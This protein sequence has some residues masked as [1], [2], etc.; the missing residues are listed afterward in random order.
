[1]NIVAYNFN[2][3]IENTDAGIALN[4]RLSRTA[5]VSQKNTV[6]KN[7]NEMNKSHFKNN[8]IKTKQKIAIYKL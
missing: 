5:Q 6:L 7:S 1:M 3:S 2:P 8:K 4:L